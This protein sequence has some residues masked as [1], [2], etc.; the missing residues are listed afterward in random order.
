MIGASV[1]VSIE[2]HAL[3]A[4]DYYSRLRPKYEINVLACLALVEIE[5]TST[6]TFIE[7]RTQSV[8]LGS[9]GKS[10]RHQLVKSS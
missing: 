8:S 3:S 4:L 7:G 2:V 1:C 5:K 9:F 6:H 10:T